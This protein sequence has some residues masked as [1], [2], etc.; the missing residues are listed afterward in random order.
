MT[1]GQLQGLVVFDLDGTLL[2][3][4]TVCEVLARPLGQGQRM[5]ELERFRSRE[6]L[7]AAREEM[8]GWYRSASA[9]GNLLR[10]LEDARLADGTKNGVSLLRA[11]GV[12]VGIA[13][14]TWSFAVE[15]FAR[16]LGVEYWLGTE[17]QD[18]GEITH[19]WPEDKARWVQELAQRLQIPDERTAAVGDSAGDYAMLG[20][21]AVPIFVDAELSP[22]RPGWLHRPAESI[23]WV[24]KHLVRFWGLPLNKAPE[25]A[26]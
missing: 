7:Q 24:A 11:H 16:A 6:E 5:Q 3:G 15:Y 10:W 4:L 19:V 14:I 1:N 8:A 25:P 26:T 17:L 12:A 9:T 22:P 20:T 18:S 23:E 21:V 2:R 13:S